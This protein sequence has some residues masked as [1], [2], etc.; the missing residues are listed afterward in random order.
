MSELGSKALGELGRD[1]WRIHGFGRAGGP[2]RHGSFGSVGLCIVCSGDED[3]CMGRAQV[4][5]GRL[6]VCTREHDIFH[7]SYSIGYWGLWG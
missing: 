5:S 1:G 7:E 6:D 4:L 3:K 2:D